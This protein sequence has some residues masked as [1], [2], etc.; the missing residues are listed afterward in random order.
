MSPAR[1]P[2]SNEESG[3]G[4]YQSR[5]PR[6]QPVIYPLF[7]VET[8]TRTI[9][10]KFLIDTG[11]SVTILPRK[12]ANE[13]CLNSIPLHLSPANK[14]DIQC[15]GETSTDIAFLGIH[16]YKLT[17]VLTDTVNPFLSTNFLWHYGL[18]VNCKNTTNIGSTLRNPYTKY[19][20]TTVT[21]S[22]KLYAHY[23][24]TCQL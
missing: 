7:E 14:Q 17:V 18:L 9:I 23:S 20:L 5:L 1:G 12:N 8:Q 22:Q 4:N 2:M 13:L 6:V 3:L 16:Q 19:Q 24:K 10:P 15:Y 21:S 11:A